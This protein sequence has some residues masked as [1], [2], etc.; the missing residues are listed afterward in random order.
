M[1]CPGESSYCNSTFAPK[2][3]YFLGKFPWNIALGKGHYFQRQHICPRR[4]FPLRQHKHFPSKWLVIFEGKK[5]NLTIYL[6][7]KK[8]PNGKNLPE[9]TLRWTN[10]TNVRGQ[11][12]VLFFRVLW[13]V[14]PQVKGITKIRAGEA[15]AE[16]RQSGRIF[17]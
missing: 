15:I 6:F 8:F 13:R 17:L 2:K 4:S 7:F 16:C 12:H 10:V 14:N 3:A 5:K 11:R 1:H 9:K